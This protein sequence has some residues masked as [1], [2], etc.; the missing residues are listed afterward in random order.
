MTDAIRAFIAYLVALRRQLLALV[1][2][3]DKE[4]ERLSK[5]G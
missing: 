4:I 3:I 5:E 2:H 1:G